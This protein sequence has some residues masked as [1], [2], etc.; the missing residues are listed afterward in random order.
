MIPVRVNSFRYEFILVP[1]CSSVFVYMIPVRMSYRYES[2]RYEF[3]PVLVPV[4][5]VRARGM[6]FDHICKGGT[7]FRSG[8]R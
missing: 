7:R 2:Y 3:T 4:R 8:T 6:R 1:I 5:N